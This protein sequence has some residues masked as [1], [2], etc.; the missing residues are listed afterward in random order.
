MV[1]VCHDDIV[2]HPI[3]QPYDNYNENIWPHDDEDKSI[4]NIVSFDFEES[5]SSG[6]TQL[7]IS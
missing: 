3:P 1:D 7:H 4:L 2:D 5:I 6:P